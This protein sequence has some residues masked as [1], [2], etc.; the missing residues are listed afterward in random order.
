MMLL[1]NFLPPDGRTCSDFD[2]I[3]CYNASVD[4]NAEVSEKTKTVA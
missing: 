2:P 1:P 4:E 3:L